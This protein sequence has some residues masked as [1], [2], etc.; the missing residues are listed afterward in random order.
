MHVDSFTMKV[1]KL[2]KT[3]M[4][5]SSNKT[6]SALEAGGAVVKNDRKQSD[7]TAGDE[8]AIIE[9]FRE[10]N[11]FTAFRSLGEEEKIS[12]IDEIL[13]APDEAGQKN[14]I[15]LQIDKLAATS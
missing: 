13:A 11:V 8:Y 5:K 1:P 14:K 10:A 2:K 9:S 6:K 3:D 4:K 12:I 7:N 15:K